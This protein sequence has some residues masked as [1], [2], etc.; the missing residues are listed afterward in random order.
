MSRHSGS[1]YQNAIQDEEKSS[2]SEVDKG[3]QAIASEGYDTGKDSAFEPLSLRGREIGQ[4]DMT[5]M[6]RTMYSWSIKKI[7]KVRVSR[8]AKEA[9]HH[10]KR[11]KGKKNKEQKEAVNELEQSI[12]LV[13]A[14]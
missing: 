4:R 8:A 9:K 1:A 5:E 11:M 14:G 10:E 13:K 2:P 7:D 6:S 3:I 12:I